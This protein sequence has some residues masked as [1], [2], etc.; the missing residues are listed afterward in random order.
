MSIPVI[1]RMLDMYELSEDD[2][3]RAYR[4]C[5]QMFWKERVIAEELRLQLCT[6]LPNAWHVMVVSAYEVGLISKADPLLLKKAL[7]EGTLFS[8]ELL[9]VFLS[10]MEKDVKGDL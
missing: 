4:A 8:E 3:N 6:V 7:I 10:N 5:C 2:N 1:K 9:P